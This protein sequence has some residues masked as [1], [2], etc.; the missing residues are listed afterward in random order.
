MI[1]QF[2]FFLN[3][4]GS[5]KWNHFQIRTTLRWKLSFYIKLLLFMSIYR[6]CFFCHGKIKQSCLLFACSKRTYEC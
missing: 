2:F 6:R 4:F 3:S 1:M 5:C